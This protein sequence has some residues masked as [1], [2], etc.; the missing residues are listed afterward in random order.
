MKPSVRHYVYFDTSGIERLFSQT[1]SYEERE[2]VI[3][4]T[5]KSSESKKRSVNPKL[6][7]NFLAAGFELAGQK[8][9]NEQHDQGTE[10]KQMLFKPNEQKLLQLEDY[11]RANDRYIVGPAKFVLAQ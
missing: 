7:G 4:R 5:D 2:L 3:S 8:E 10:H 9:K 11:I 6:S 1:S